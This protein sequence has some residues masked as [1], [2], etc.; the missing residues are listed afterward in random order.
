[1]A[2]FDGR[3]NLIPVKKGD[4]GRNPNGRPKGAISV[5]TL[6]EKVGNLVVP[7]NIQAQLKAA[8]INVSNKKIDEALIH[9]L[10]TKGFSGDIQAIKEYYDRRDG[11]PKQ[12]LEHTGKDEEA[13]QVE[14]KYSKKAVEEIE[15]IILREHAARISGK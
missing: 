14:T 2:R 12:Q 8:G 1:M 7:K 5:K 13:I 11:K 15:N 4:K 9:V 6:A 3:A 10:V